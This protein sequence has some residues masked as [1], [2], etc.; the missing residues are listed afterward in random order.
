MKRKIKT[1]IASY[2]KYSTHSSYTFPKIRRYL[3]IEWETAVLLTESIISDVDR[4]V[5]CEI[6]KMKKN[7]AYLRICILLCIYT[8]VA[9]NICVSSTAN[10]FEYKLGCSFPEPSNFFQGCVSSRIQ[11]IHFVCCWVLLS[12]QWPDVAALLRSFTLL[13]QSI[14]GTEHIPAIHCFLLPVNWLI[15]E[16]III[17]SVSA[18][19]LDRVET[20]TIVILPRVTLLELI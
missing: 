10:I 3:D 1:V 8:L 2:F 6:H 19:K 11:L 7:K 16:L 4:S 18:M 5:N 14:S 12:F 17:V 15:Y 13:I 20:I 9:A